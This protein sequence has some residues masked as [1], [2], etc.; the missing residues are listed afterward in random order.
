[1][2]NFM[3]I[4]C[5]AVSFLSAEIIE[6]STIADMDKYKEEGVLFLYDIDNTLVTLPQDLG[7]DQW[8]QERLKTN[9]SRIENKQKALD[10]TLNE[11]AAFQQLSKPIEVEP[12]SDKIIK[13]QQDDH[14]MM[15]GFTTRGVTMS[16]NTII[17]LEELG[18]D[19]S[20][21]ALI[22]HDYLFV[23]GRSV[24]YRNG[25]LFTAATH[26]GT[27]LFSFLDK[28]GINP[29]KIV[30]INDKWDNLR[31]VEETCEK[32]KIPFIGLRYGYLDERVRAFDS[33]VTD[34]QI[35]RFES[36]L[37]GL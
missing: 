9:R 1:M 10:R 8:F 23:Q 3:L 21:S 18:I 28:L 19:F 35:N 27:T 24:I 15:M 29:R 32:R 37:S 31:A 30:F 20:R 34:K 26:K 14:I 2:K 33:A 16:R 4:F 13:A 25:V 17:Q 36:I 22:D 7:T 5:T 6:S 11:W 12:G